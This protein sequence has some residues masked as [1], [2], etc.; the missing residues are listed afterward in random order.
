MGKKASELNV[1]LAEEFRYAQS[2]Y[3]EPKSPAINGNA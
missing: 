3:I 2:Q 1:R